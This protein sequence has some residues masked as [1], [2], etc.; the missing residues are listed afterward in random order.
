MHG[1]CGSGAPTRMAE[2]RAARDPEHA[3]DTPT[4]H[5]HDPLHRAGRA[6][7][8]ADHARLRGSSG[9][10]LGPRFAL[11]TRAGS[12]APGYAEGPAFELSTLRIAGRVLSGSSSAVL[13]GATVSADGVDARSAADG[14]FT[15]AGVR[16]RQ[17]YT[18][19]AFAPGYG[20]REQ[21]NVVVDL[22]RSVTG[23]ELR[24]A[25]SSGTY[26]LV[27]LWSAA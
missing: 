26:S 20:L 14:S 19:R 3:D 1:L 6:R 4:G 17:R 27:P 23:L 25:A 12:T 13:S 9:L 2:I 10:P 22:S 18:V 11:D 24:L 8:A 21:A 7:A 16:P 15:L 5:P